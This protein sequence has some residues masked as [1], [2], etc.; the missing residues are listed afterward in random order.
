VFHGD[1]V[2]E[3]ESQKNNSLLKTM[4]D[5]Y[6]KIKRGKIKR[7]LLYWRFC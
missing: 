5:R 6:L 7:V 1:F 4:I 2:Q 3:K